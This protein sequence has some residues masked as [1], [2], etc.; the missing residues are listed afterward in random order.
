APVAGGDL[1]G[2]RLADDVVVGQ[3]RALLVEDHAGALAGAGAGGGEDRDGAG[4]DLLGDLRPVGILRGGGRGGAGLGGGRARGGGDGLVVLQLVVDD[5]AAEGQAAGEEHAG[6]H[7]AAGADPARAAAR[8][9]RAGG[10]S[11]R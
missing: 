7:E 1:E 6:D 8:G 10:C 11:C 2:A 9:G 3:D 4:R 5:D